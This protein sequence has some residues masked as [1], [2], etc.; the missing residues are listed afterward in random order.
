M[1]GVQWSVKV[2]AYPKRKDR[3]FARRV[4]QFIRRRVLNYFVFTAKPTGLAPLAT[5]RRRWQAEARR[6]LEEDKDFIEMLTQVRQKSLSTGSDFGDYPELRDTVERLQPRYV[7][8][9]GSGISTAVI[10]FSMWRN[11]QKIGHKGKVVSMD[12]SE[13]YSENARES[14]PQFLEDY[15][16]FHH[17]P[18]KESAYSKE[19][20]IARGV[21]YESWPLYPYSFSYID[22]PQERRGPAAM[23]CFDADILHVALLAKSAVVGMIDQRVTRFGTTRSRHLDGWNF[24][25]RM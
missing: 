21:R 2:D 16:E 8:E 22:G 15:V 5:A 4:F 14:L 3:Y 18:P 13:K 12:E 24:P 19:D 10:A 20:F 25:A 11:H 17:S 23:K 6:R 9:C 1:S 7:L